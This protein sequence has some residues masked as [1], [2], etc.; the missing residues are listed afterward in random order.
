VSQREF[1]EI[2]FSPSI[3]YL[4]NKKWAIGTEFVFRGEFGNGR[5]WYRSFDSDTYG[6]RIFTDYSV[7][8]SFFVHAE[9]ENLYTIRKPIGSEVASTTISVPG[10]MA[11]L[12][13]TFGLGKNVTGKILIQ[14]N[15]IHDETKALYASPW[16][17]RFGFDLKKLKKVQE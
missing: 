7:Y 11:G 2:D 9:F 4:V 5:R 15:F 14:Y 3:A 13:K 17:V 16:V 1:L 6:G 10:A 8:K 12:G